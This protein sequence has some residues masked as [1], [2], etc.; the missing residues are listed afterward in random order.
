MFDV[1]KELDEGEC[2]S[3]DP[4]SPFTKFVVAS[5]FA[6]IGGF[7]IAF[8]SVGAEVAI[9][10][11]LD[12]FCRSVLKRH[13]PK[14]KLIEDITLAVPSDLADANL[15]TAGFPCQ[16]VSLARGN[17]G[18][19]G[20][21]GTQTSLFFKLIELLDTR[22][23]E[24]LVLEN[25]VGLLN[26]H[27]GCDF[28]IILRELTRR[29]YAVSWRVLNARYF[30]TPQS[31]SRVFMVAWK[32]D[33]HR[34]VTSLFETQPGA[35][36]GNARTG[37]ITPT[38]H[39]TTGAIVPQVAYCVAATSGRHTGNDWARSYISYRD[40]VR[41]PTA[42]ESERLQGFEAGWTIPGNDYRTQ[43]RGHDSERYHAVGNAVA[44]PV[45]KWVAN[46]IVQA[47]SARSR[48][49]TN[50]IARE[51]L[52]LAPDLRKSTET[53]SFQ[54]IMSEV[55]NGSFAYRWKGCGLA[56]GDLIIEGA[57]APA[58]S[59]EIPSRFVDL[60]DQDVP[61]ERYFLTANAAVGILRRAD[62]VGRTLF[63]PMHSA[64]ECLAKNKRPHS[65][66][67][68]EKAGEVFAKARIRP[69]SSEQRAT[70]KRAGRGTN[71][72]LPVLC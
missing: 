34:A 43:P 19:S 45:V 47:K 11:E 8:E 22:P 44:V 28:A 68:A 16:D 58:P 55:D 15:W 70:V 57:T 51:V 17:H 21:K 67:S 18:R 72:T 24:V 64:L 52:A 69:P 48:P 1:R 66:A 7:D 31:R 54:K 6:G 9:Q 23:P 29:G 10:C 59:V 35:K 53:L 49:V 32:D 26:S 33:V 38:F 37:F 27:K 25:V 40:R 46:R 65:T 50:D 42:S 12:P 56:V 60:L 39:A 2:H 14:A 30:G 61:D 4:A 63:A 71:R 13:W 20:L 62:A 36:V 3:G 41:R 5:L